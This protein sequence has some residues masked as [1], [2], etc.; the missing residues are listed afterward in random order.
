MIEEG[1]FCSQLINFIPVHLA[2]V[3][4]EQTGI[5]ALLLV[6][7]QAITGHIMVGVV[8]TLGDLRGFLWNCLITSHHKHNY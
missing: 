4:V 6:L 3:R 8:W 5:L 1:G 7:L 2:H